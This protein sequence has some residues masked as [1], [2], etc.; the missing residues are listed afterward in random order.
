MKESRC[1]AGRGL[2][3]EAGEER[4]AEEGDGE[5]GGMAPALYTLGVYVVCLMDVS[6]LMCG[7]KMWA[8]GP[9]VKRG[10]WHATRLVYY[11]CGSHPCPRWCRMCN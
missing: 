1:A 6:A 11:I 10:W 4:R 9:N 3:R 8:Q 2:G 5:N 7:G